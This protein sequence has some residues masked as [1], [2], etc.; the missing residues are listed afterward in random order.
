MRVKFFNTISVLN[1]FNI[2]ENLIQLVWLENKSELYHVI[3]NDSLLKFLLIMTP[4]AYKNILPVHRLRLDSLHL[5]LGL[6]R[7]MQGK[8]YLS[9]FME[10]ILSICNIV[11]FTV[12]VLREGNFAGKIAARRGYVK[13]S[14][15]FWIT[16]RHSVEDQVLAGCYLSALQ[17]AYWHFDTTV[18]VNEAYSFCILLELVLWRVHAYSIDPG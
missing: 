16:E 6:R 18:A 1:G 2:G 14:A 17:I 3:Y 10:E 12:C 8:H 4:H 5:E 7:E 15:L 9:L 13:R 11:G